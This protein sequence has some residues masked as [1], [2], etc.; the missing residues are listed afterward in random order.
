MSWFR[1]RCG[2]FLAQCHRVYYRRNA[3]GIANSIGVGLGSLVGLAKGSEDEKSKEASVDSASIISGR[4]SDQVHTSAW[5]RSKLECEL[6][7]P[8]RIDWQKLI[9]IFVISA[10]SETQ[11]PTVRLCCCCCC[12]CCCFLYKNNASSQVRP[13]S[14]HAFLRRANNLKLALAKLSGYWKI[15]LATSLR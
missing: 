15:N 9:I 3:S 14:A 8:Y 10:G 11:K 6:T 4:A 5:V 7:V 1:F 12:C 2:W 13:S